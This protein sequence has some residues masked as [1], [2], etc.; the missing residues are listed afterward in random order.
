MRKKPTRTDYAWIFNATKSKG[1]K[2]SVFTS[3]VIVGLLALVIDYVTLPA[4]NLQ[5]SGIYMLFAFY[6]IVFG[7]LNFLFSQRF[8]TLVR[9]SV[10]IGAL[11][12]IFVVVMSLLG[13]EL[14]NS[15]SSCSV[16]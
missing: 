5:N 16:F 15:T 7:I 8:S 2:K 6:F 9:N 1:N 12:V 10:A 3:L 4:Y 11:L 13:S 14:I